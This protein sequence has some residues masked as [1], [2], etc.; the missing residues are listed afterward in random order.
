MVSPPLV[1]GRSPECC[2][3][4]GCPLL[5]AFCRAV[6]AEYTAIAILGFEDLATRGALVEVK[7]G[8]G[9]HRS[10]PPVPAERTGNGRLENHRCRPKNAA[11]S[12][13]GRRLLGM[14]LS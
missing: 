5:R 10:G 8:V 13:S 14:S 2:Y 6:R 12:R 4:S 3:S 9:G 1:S 11:T 7:A